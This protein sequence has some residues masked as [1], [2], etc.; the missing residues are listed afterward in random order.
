MIGIGGLFWEGRTEIN[1]VRNTGMARRRAIRVSFRALRGN[2]SGGSA[3]RAVRSADPA[4]AAGVE[5]IGMPIRRSH[6]RPF[7][8]SPRRFNVL[9][10]RNRRIPLDFAAD[11]KCRPWRCR[12]R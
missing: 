1:S 5:R 12:V 3:V 10:L 4:G 11:I 7:P 9:T 8:F 2:S 6:A